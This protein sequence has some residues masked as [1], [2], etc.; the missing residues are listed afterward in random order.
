MITELTQIDGIFQK[1]KVV[2]REHDLTA[3]ESLFQENNKVVVVNG[4]GG[5]GKTTLAH[6]FLAQ[7]NLPYQYVAWLDCSRSVIEAIGLNI[8]LRENLKIFSPITNQL[9]N[10]FKKVIKAMRD[11]DGNG[12]LILDNVEGE[13]WTKIVANALPP[14]SKWKLL[15]TSRAH[16]QN[17]AQ[18]KL[19]EVS[20][21]SAILIFLDNFFWDNQDKNVKKQLDDLQ[22]ELRLLNNKM[23]EFFNETDSSTH[24]TNYFSFQAEQ[25]KDDLEQ[26]VPKVANLGLN[27]Y[28]ILELLSVIEVH[29]LMIELSA[30]VLN[31]KIGEVSISTYVEMLK[32]RELNAP[33]LQRE[34]AVRH[35]TYLQ[36]E[37]K[38]DQAL[39]DQ[40]TRLYEHILLTFDFFDY[41]ET[42]KHIMRQFVCLPTNASPS[43]FDLKSWLSISEEEQIIFEN[44]VK[45]L[46]EL[47]WLQQA[48]KNHYYMHPFMQDVFYYKF[49]IEYQEVE[50]LASFV[51][52]KVGSGENHDPISRFL[53]LPIAEQVE[54]NIA[55]KNDW[56]LAVYIHNLACAYLELATYRHDNEDSFLR[57]IKNKQE[58]TDVNS[59]K[60]LMYSDY[61]KQLPNNLLYQ[62]AAIYTIN[63]IDIMSL[64]KKDLHFVVGSFYQTLGICLLLM[65]DLTQSEISF[66]NA[67]HIYKFHS[68]I[69]EIFI[70]KTKGYLALIN[71]FKA[72]ITPV[73]KYIYTKKKNK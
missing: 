40:K 15:I 62:K 2:G 35:Q 14:N 63:A 42:E 49:N 67:I 53:W 7:T 26:F 34:V 66:N 68:K 65:Q 32:R 43:V 46:Y 6:Y 56:V 37:V 12:L 17:V 72:Q 48:P 28:D 23:I 13:S 55:K 33:N 1:S 45:R 20:A 19:G 52:N 73:Y 16:L 44:T 59:I 4:M 30:K 39:L 36:K 8:E 47:G 38:A 25:F 22:L 27:F 60:D 10:E 54:K 71:E 5:I 21:A 3:I 51:F 9:E 58:N 29:T 18:Y 64:S 11:L 57:D 24:K 70:E 31:E 61:F 50:K 41:L 69:G